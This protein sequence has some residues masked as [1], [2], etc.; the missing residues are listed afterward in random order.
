MHHERAPPPARGQEFIDRHHVPSVF[1]TAEIG[2]GGGP[3]REFS[4]TVRT[5]ALPDADVFGEATPGNWAAAFRQLAGILPDDKAS[6]VVIDELPYLMDSSGAFESVLQR[7]WDRELSRKPVLQPL[8]DPVDGGRDRAVAVVGLA[9]L[10]G[11]RAEAAR[12]RDRSCGLSPLA[13]SSKPSPPTAN[14]SSTQDTSTTAALC[15][16]ASASAGGLRAGCPDRVV[17][18]CHVSITRCLCAPPAMLM[19][20]CRLP[21]SAANGAYYLSSPAGPGLID[22]VF[23]APGVA[24]A[25]FTG[26]GRARHA[27]TLRPRATSRARQNELTTSILRH[28]HFRQITTKNGHRARKVNRRHQARPPP[29]ARRNPRTTTIPQVTRE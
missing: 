19:A 15:D 27:A 21:A 20:N 16:L 6:V 24:G 25:G 22:R 17:L 28:G 4:E 1:Y 2:F 26:V 9:D 7:T 18:A 13:R 5:S 3:L 14:A 12:R 11:L 10:A 29:D 8:V 23:H